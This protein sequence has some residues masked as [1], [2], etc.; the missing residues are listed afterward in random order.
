MDWKLDKFEEKLKEKEETQEEFIERAVT[1]IR[2]RIS[3][4]SDQG[5][6]SSLVVM[7]G[8]T[9]IHLSIESRGAEIRIASFALEEIIRMFSEK[10]P[11]ELNKEKTD[12][13][14]KNWKKKKEEKGC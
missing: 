8:D 1:T 13:F 10:T 9:K 11:M 3:N 7:P 5:P 14:L 2:S 4:L 6:L 12:K